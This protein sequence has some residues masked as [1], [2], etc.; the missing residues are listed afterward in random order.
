MAL[1]VRTV[2]TEVGFCEGPTLRSDGELVITSMSQGRLYKIKDAKKELLADVGGSPNGATEDRDGTIYVAQAGG[3]PRGVKTGPRVTG[4]VQ[5][6]QP[7]GS[8]H[9]LTKDPLAPN[10]LCFGRD[11]FLYVT[12]PTRDR[13]ARDDGRLW[14]CDHRTGEAELLMSTPWFPNGIGFGLDDA[15]YV[16]RSGEQR[17][18]RFSL[19]NGKLGKEELFVQMPFGR[20]DGFLF[21][22]DGNL[23]VCAIASVEPEGTAGQIQ[24]YDR[25]GSLIDTFAPGPLRTYTNIALGPDRILYI[26]DSD[27]GNVLAVDGWPKAGL[28]LYPFRG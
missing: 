11:G 14:R 23:V 22:V 26:T 19:D 13:P 25:N 10:D 12:D 1:A 5:V 24:T 9:Y 20:P 16:A 15:L 8:F 27:G 7:D 17:I 28:P 6:V 21:D 3:R 4:G 18:V 2:A